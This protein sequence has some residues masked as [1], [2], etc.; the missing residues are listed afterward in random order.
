AYHAEAADDAD[1]VLRF[2]PAA[3]EYAASIGAHR[4]SA[5]Q[6]ER[7]LR[8]GTGLPAN[9]LATLLEGRSYECY[10]TEQT[11]ESIDALARAVEYWRAF[12][13]ELREGAAMSQL[14]RRLWC[15]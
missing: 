6:Y 7:A 15:G 14:S 10:L 13:D 2:A 11:R 5:A 9:R 8:F 12:G 3:A 4:E 1:A